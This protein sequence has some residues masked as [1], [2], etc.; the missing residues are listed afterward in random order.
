MD[1]CKKYFEIF[2][3]VFHNDRIIAQHCDVTYH[4]NVNIAYCDVHRIILYNLSIKVV[5]AEYIHSITSKIKF[6][7]I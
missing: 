1:G 6:I 5:L 2:S 7:D 3:S 4:L